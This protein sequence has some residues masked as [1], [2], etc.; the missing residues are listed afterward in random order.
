MWQT[1]SCKGSNDKFQ[2]RRNPHYAEAETAKGKSRFQLEFNWGCKRQ[3]LEI[4]PGASPWLGLTVHHGAHRAALPTVNEGLGRPQDLQI[5]GYKKDYKIDLW[6]LW[7]LWL[8]LHYNLDSQSQ[9][10]LTAMHEGLY[11][12]SS[13]GPCFVNIQVQFGRTFWNSCLPP[14]EKNP[15]GRTASL[16]FEFK[17]LPF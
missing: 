1:N 13:S 8:C 12:R 9:I 2:Q 15:Y 17:R 4:I 14:S 3:G 6:A 16:H 10:F 7:W 5:F 11:E